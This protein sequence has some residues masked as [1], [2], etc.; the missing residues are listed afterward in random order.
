MKTRFTI[1]VVVNIFLSL[2][3]IA[4]IF[5]LV[6]P[7]FTSRHEFD[8][9]FLAWYQNPNKATKVELE[10]QRRL[11]YLLDFETDGI[12]VVLIAVTGYGLVRSWR[13]LNKNR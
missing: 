12:V 10:H 2:I 11:N 8:Q 3:L 9:A 4:L 5:L 13:S 1:L 6:I 7:G